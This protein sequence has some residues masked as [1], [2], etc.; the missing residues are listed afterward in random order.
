M[1]VGTQATVKALSSGDLERLGARIILGNTYHL[2]LRPGAERVAAFG[3]LHRFMSWPR[4]ILTDSGG[5]QVF[6]LRERRTVDDDGVT[7]RSHLDGSEQRLTPERAMAIQTALGS[8]IAMAF[9]ECPPSDA[10]RA[11]IEAAMARTTRWARRCVDAPAAPGQLRF[12]IVQGGV[13]LDLRRAHLAEIAALPFDGLALG[14]LGVGEAPEVMYGVIDAIA[15]RDAGGAPAL[16]DGRRHARGHLDGDR[17]RRRHVRLRDA[18]AQRAQRPA[19]RPRRPPQHRQRAAPGRSR[20]PSRTAARASAARRTAAAI[21]RTCSA[22][23]S[24]CTTG[25]R[26]STTSST[27][28]AWRAARARRSSPGHFRR[29]RGSPTRMAKRVGVL[30]S[31]CGRL[32]GSDVAE[33]M[34]TLLVIERAGA[35]AICAGARRRSGGRRRSPDRRRARAVRATRAPRRRASPA[36]RC[37]RSPSLNVNAIDA[38]IVPGGAGADRDAV[39]LSREARA[40][41]D[42]PRRRAACCARCCSRTAR[43]ASSACRRCSR[44]ACS[45]P[46][47]GVR[48]TVGSKGTPCGEARR[49]HGRRRSSLRARGRHR[50]SEGARLHDARVPRRRGAGCPA[51]ARA[52]DRLVRAVVA[53][54]KDRAPAP[55]ARGAA[56]RRRSSY[57]SKPRF[58]LI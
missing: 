1:P 51:V 13:H 33:T 37:F 54:A 48:V 5:Y 10:P 14:G 47:A 32:D 36:R 6:S 3:G 16:P 43:W 26:A 38:L 52:V 7:F 12:G 55:R 8:D 29:R 34:L 46:A 50:R 11:V 4:A 18:D 15:R 41:S 19:V 23:R 45:G 53:N 24:C 56:R 27:T 17:R 44:R 39:R 22:P 40:L 42:P 31:G 35:Q 57:W 25:S 20:S 9:D 49:G 28:W 2:A 30:L 58:R 21:S